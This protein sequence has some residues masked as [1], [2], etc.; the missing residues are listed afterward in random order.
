MAIQYAINFIGDVRCDDTLR[1]SFN[2]IPNTQLFAALAE[3]GY[4]FSMDEFE[5]SVNLLHV[6]CQTAEEAADLFQVVWW[7][8]MLLMD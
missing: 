3:K 5:E 1:R 8:K 4:D 2:K 7:F 6:K